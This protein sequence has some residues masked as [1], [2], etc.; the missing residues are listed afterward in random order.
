MVLL[1]ECVSEDHP[2]LVDLA[3]VFLVGTAGSLMAFI[4]LDIPLFFEVLQVVVGGPI[5][6]EIAKA[7]AIYVA[8]VFLKVRRVSVAILIGWVIGSGFQIAETL[9]YATFFGYQSLFMG[10]VLPTIVDDYA[11]VFRSLFA[12]GSHALFGAMEGAGI[13]FSRAVPEGSKTKSSR[14]FLWLAMAVVL[15]MLWN[16]NAFFNGEN[17][18]VLTIVSVVFELGVIPI[19]L[20]L[21]DAGIR[22]GN[23][24][25]REREA[26]VKDHDIGEIESP[27]ADKE[28]VGFGGSVP[29]SKGENPES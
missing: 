20:Y 14:F 29:D 25:R 5:I 23:R 26:V 28:T 17:R 27:S 13:L 21:L 8:I 6:E 22:D 10:Q 2:R 18:T 3:V 24:H 11:M 12:F 1:Y 16:V 7:I 15:H 4:S 19:F 9:G